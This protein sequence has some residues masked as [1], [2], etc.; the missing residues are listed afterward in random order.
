MDK[1][2]LYI[3]IAIG[4]TLI[5]ITAFCLLKKKKGNSADDGVSQNV[6]SIQRELSKMSFPQQA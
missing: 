3:G 1:K 5:G 6:K 4:V 2:K